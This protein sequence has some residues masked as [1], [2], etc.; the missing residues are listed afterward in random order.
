ML[1]LEQSFD[2]KWT[3]DK[4]GCW[5]MELR[6]GGIGEAKMTRKQEKKWEESK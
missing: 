1:S 3:S 6:C 4:K 2:E 5:W